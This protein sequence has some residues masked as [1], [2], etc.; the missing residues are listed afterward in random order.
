VDADKLNNKGVD[1]FSKKMPSLE[2]NRSIS[3]IDID[4]YDYFPKYSGNKILTPRIDQISFLSET[5]NFFKS[6]DERLFIGYI[7]TAG[8][9]TALAIAAARAW[10]ACGG[11]ANI[12][13]PSKSLQMQYSNY[14]DTTSPIF[15]AKEY[16]CINRSGNNQNTCGSKDSFLCCEHKKNGTCPQ[17]VAQKKAFQEI[18]EKPLIFTPYSYLS[19]K[20]NLAFDFYLPKGDGLLIVDEAHLL[21]EQ[22]ASILTVK[23][24]MIYFFYLSKKYGKDI[25]LTIKELFGD[26]YNVSF[27]NLP[28]TSLNDRNKKFICEIAAILRK[29]DIEEMY[30]FLLE[31]SIKHIYDNKD[32]FEDR[33]KS[34]ISGLDKFEKFNSGG[35]F[36][37]ELVK[38]FN[39]DEVDRKL[40]NLKDRLLKENIDFVMRPGVISLDFLRFFFKGYSKI[41]F[42]SGTLFRSHIERLGLISKNSINDEG[43]IEGVR[44]FEVESQIDTKRRSLHI[45][46]ANGRKVNFENIEDSFNHFSKIIVE[47]ISP[48]L[49]GNGGFIHVASNSQAKLLYDLCLQQS[50]SV[51]E[52]VRPIFFSVSSDGG[53]NTAFNSYLK[54]VEKR[55]K[56]KKIKLPSF[57]IIAARRFEGLDLKDDLARANIIV[58]VPHANQR[59]TIVASL[60]NLTGGAYSVSSTITSILQASARTV[61]HEKD[62][63][64]NICLDLSVIQLFQKVVGELPNYIS[65]AIIEEDD[66]TWIDFWEHS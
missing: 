28:L 61:R 5:N 39:K 10:I 16:I 60:D 26:S 4:T 57:F 58:K 38:Q 9:K 33:H 47:K 55:R 24:P 63:S 56:N 17:K 21:A 50:E 64:L 65:D 13:C 12:I 29:I 6:K 37:L 49:A 51:E 62:W 15:G 53:W 46:K 20:S 66:P 43:K 54:E 44:R 8:G 19:A 45:D 40:P 14:G 52:E 27:D 2:E 25:E 36:A 3:S 18:G 41:I 23:I 30:K 22:I 32:I 35:S 42:M 7:P 11:K 59:D 1:I 31:T 48:K 34:I